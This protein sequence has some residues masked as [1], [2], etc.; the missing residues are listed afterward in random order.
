MMKQE[1]K[2]QVMGSSCQKALK[3][4]KNGRVNMSEFQTEHRRSQTQVLKV[5]FF[6]NLLI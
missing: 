6:Y 4:K 3:K 5:T 2:S 1:G